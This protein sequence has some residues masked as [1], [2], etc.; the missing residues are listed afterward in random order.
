[1]RRKERFRIGC[2]EVVV[3]FGEYIG[4]ESKK[5]IK[6]DVKVLLME[7]EECGYIRDINVLK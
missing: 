3:V 6:G 2:I 7:K 5:K 4:W 1:M